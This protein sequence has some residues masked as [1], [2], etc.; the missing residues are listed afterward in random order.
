M[1][2]EYA[3]VSRINNTNARVHGLRTISTKGDI[4]KARLVASPSLSPMIK[5]TSTCSG[6]LQKIMNCTAI[7]LPGNL[8]H[9]CMISRLDDL[10]DLTTWQSP[11]GEAALQSRTSSEKT[12][13]RVQAIL[14]RQQFI[15]HKV[16]ALSLSW[17]VKRSLLFKVIIVLHSLSS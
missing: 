5:K 15:V 14:L 12:K 7:P 2:Q 10:N 3:V 11:K 13:R 6:S 1:S 4:P 16:R 9:L 17:K 8:R